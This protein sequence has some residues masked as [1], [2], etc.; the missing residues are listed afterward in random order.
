MPLKK[1]E[2]THPLISVVIPAFNA[3]KYLEEALESII[4][5]NYGL[6]EIILIDDGSTDKTAKIAQNF[7]NNI[8][9]IYQE[10]SGPAVARNKG[11]KIA[12]GEYITFLDA[13]DLWPSTTLK[14]Q[15]KFLQKYP[16]SEIV[17][18]RT[19]FIKYDSDKLLFEKIGEPRF[20]LNLGSAIYHKSVF[21]QVGLLD[22]NLTYSEDIDW[23]NRA[24]E[25]N[26]KI[27][28]HQE[29]VLFYRQHEHNMTNN[30]ST[31]ELA[32]MKVLKKSLNRR[33][34]SQQISSNQLPK[35]NDTKLN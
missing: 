30:K 34:K 12:K 2:F 13:D 17:L 20:F 4:K 15:L 16:D 8:T 33:R 22:E 28:K 9:Y 21:E 3:E 26:I 32:I 25:Q 24:R 11:I 23:F 29:I 10:N 7:L 31:E 19:Q 27:I 5:Q 18:G 14:N 6:L 35:I 1:N